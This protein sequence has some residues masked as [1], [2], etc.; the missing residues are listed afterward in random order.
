MRRAGHIDRSIRGQSSTR[1]RGLAVEAL[2]S[3]QHGVVSRAQLLILGVGQDTADRWIASGRLVVVHRG[4]FAVGH[5]LLTA[6][7][8]WMAAVLAG[9]KETVLSHVSAADLWDLTGLARPHAHVISANKRRSRP[10]ITF[11]RIQLP[12]DE[13][14]EREGIPVTTAARTIFD[15]AAMTSRARVAQAMSRAEHRLLSDSPSLIEL[16]ERYPGRR[17]SKNVK[18]ILAENRLGVDISDH[19]LETRFL[20]F[21]DERDL[22]R[23]QVNAPLSAGG[24]SFI[25]DCFW[26]RAGLVV[27]LDSRAYHADWQSA[28]RDRARDLALVAAGLRVVRVTW[29]T[30]HFD[31]DRLEAQIRDVLYARGTFAAI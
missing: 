10:G 29:H 15:L 11:H 17:G 14:S 5:R 18:S 4:V 22:P 3:R 25:V 27:E 7:G 19:E 1:L 24:Q 26:R 2:A 6:E 31:P 28:E 30:L 8:R 9:G 12:A 16:L 13:I 23:P 20:E 21:I